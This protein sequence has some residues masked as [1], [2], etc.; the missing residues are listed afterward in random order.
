MNHQ[1]QA[2]YGDFHIHIGSTSSG[3]P[4]KISA[5]RQLTFQAIAHEASARKGLDLIGII[6]CHAPGVLKDIEY[7]LEQGEMTPLDGGGIRYGRTT[8]ILGVELELR[9]DNYGPAHVLCYM[10]TY[11]AMCH[12]SEWMSHHIRNMN[13]S[14]QRIYV[15]WQQLQEETAAR[16]GLFIPAHVFTPHKS[17]YGSCSNRLADVADLSLVDAIEL[18]LSADTAMASRLSE[19]DQFPFLTNSDAHSLQKIAREYNKLYLQEPTFQELAMALRGE[20]GRHIAANYGL[21]PLLGKYHKTTCSNGHLWND[22][23]ADACPI[24]GSTRRIAGVADRIDAIADRTEADAT[25]GLEYRPPYQEQI[26]LEHIP[27]IGPKVLDRLIVHFGS[28]MNVLHH[29]TLEELAAVVPEGIAHR[30]VLGR[31]GQLQVRSGGG[32]TYGKVMSD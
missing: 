27:G 15:S 32:G 24:C 19:L 21:N 14:T 7:M 29:A 28:E 20:G 18:G 30:I 12:F 17:V 1:C 8:I 31:A 10:P 5:S 9:V 6:D 26:P 2:Y 4:V 13:L 23:Q 3:A 22:L 11:E 16:G 25:S